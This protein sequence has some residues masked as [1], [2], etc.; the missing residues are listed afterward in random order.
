M[1]CT[2]PMRSH[3]SASME[4]EWFLELLQR[5]GSNHSNLLVKILFMQKV[6][7]HE[8]QQKTIVITPI[9]PTR[10]MRTRLTP[11]L[12]SYHIT[13]YSFEIVVGIC[14]FY[15]AALTYHMLVRGEVFLMLGLILV[16]PFFACAILFFG[17][18]PQ[19]F[20]CSWLFPLWGIL[21]FFLGPVWGNLFFLLLGGLILYTFREQWDYCM[22]Q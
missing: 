2:Y 19:W 16:P 22:I 6:S 20:W 10:K 7:L 13:T 14:A 1:H 12:L 9:P 15:L 3:S 21:L 4:K 5:S 18:I 17:M 11:I 8:N